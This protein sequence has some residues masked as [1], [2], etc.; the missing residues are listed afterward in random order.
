MERTRPRVSVRGVI[1]AAPP[2]DYHVVPEVHRHGRFGLGDLR[3]IP[4]DLQQTVPTIFPDVVGLAG[5]PDLQTLATIIIVK[6]IVV[7]VIAPAIP[8]SVHGFD[9]VV[10]NGG[11]RRLAVQRNLVPTNF[12][13]EDRLDRVGHAL[14]DAVRYVHKVK[15]AARKRARTVGGGAVVRYVVVQPAVGAGW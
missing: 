8:L 4:A 5:V 9:D 3:A 12:A 14:E 13:R 2:I 7:D 6:P 1:D 11:I 15:G 10:M